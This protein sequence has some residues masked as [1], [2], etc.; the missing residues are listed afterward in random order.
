MSR[1]PSRAAFS[2]TASV[3][4]IV[5][6]QTWLAQSAVLVQRSLANV[7][8][9]V[10]SKCLRHRTPCMCPS[11][12]HCLCCVFLTKDNVSRGDQHRLFAH[13]L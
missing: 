10:G 2:N 4:I 11:N 1:V 7:T 13:N 8:G 9:E 3:D 6:A 12:D 5:G